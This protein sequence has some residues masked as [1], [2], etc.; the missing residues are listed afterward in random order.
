MEAETDGQ[1]AR[2]CL[3]LRFKNEIQSMC[4]TVTREGKDITRVHTWQCL[5]RS[6][7]RHC[8]TPHRAV[9]PPPSP[10]PCSSPSSLHVIYLHRTSVH[11]THTAHVHTPTPRTHIHSDTYPPTHTHSVI[12]TYGYTDSHRMPYQHACSQV[13]QHAS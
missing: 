12:T 5:G 13:C 1:S 2:K 11:H 10:E 4:G 8:G 7:R 6:S 3:E 9:P